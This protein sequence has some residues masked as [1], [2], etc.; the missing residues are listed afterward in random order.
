MDGGSESEIRVK[1]S[2]KAIKN[3]IANFSYCHQC[4][5]KAEIHLDLYD[6]SLVTSVNKI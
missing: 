3:E 6:F 1:T 2:S 4:W 5:K